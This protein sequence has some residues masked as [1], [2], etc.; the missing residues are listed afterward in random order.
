MFFPGPPAKM[1]IWGASDCSVFAKIS[2]WNLYFFSLLDG[3]ILLWIHLHSPVKL[4]YSFN[5]L[6]CWNIYNFVGLLMFFYSKTGE[7]RI[8]RLFRHTPAS[9]FPDPTHSLK[10]S[11]FFRTFIIPWW[12][13]VT[14]GF[15]GSYPYPKEFLISPDI[16]RFLMDLCNSRFFQILPILWKHPDF[17]GYLSFPD[18][19][20]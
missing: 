20:L 6:P 3:S 16:Y 7:Q 5:Y 12:I 18:E 17:P 4:V 9:P 15:S 19:S 14:T 11:W 2:M 8:T 10:S 1:C 13:S